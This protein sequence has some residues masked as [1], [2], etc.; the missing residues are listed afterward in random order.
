MI[1]TIASL[2][3]LYRTFVHI[4]L[5]YWAGHPHRSRFCP[6]ADGE[7]LP[8]FARDLDRNLRAMSAQLRAGTYRFSPFLERRV[9]VRGG[10]EKRFSQATLRDTLVQKA[11]AAIVE[12][13]LDPLLPDSLH[14]F[15]RRRPGGPGLHR[16]LSHAAQVSAA[17]S[18]WVLQEDVRA[19]YDHIRHDRLLETLSPLLAGQQPVLDLYAAYLVAPRQVDGVLQPRSMGLPIGSTLANALANVYLL[20]LDHA[21]GEAGFHAMRY[22]DDVLVWAAGQEEALAARQVIVE[23]TQAYG[24]SLN[25]EKSCLAPPSAPFIYLGYAFE[26]PHMRIGPRATEKLRRKVARVTARNRWPRLTPADLHTPRGRVLL[27]RLIG[28]VNAQITGN[29]LGAWPRYFARAEFDTQFRELDRWIRQ[30]VRAALLH[31]WRESDAR[32]LPTAQLQALGLNSLVHETWRWRKAWRARNRSLLAQAAQLTR[33]RASLELTKARAWDRY[34][35]CHRFRPGPDGLTLD[36]IAAD[37]RTFLL[38]LQTELLAGRYRFGAFLEYARPRQGRDEPRWIARPGLADAVVA[39]ALSAVLSTALEQHLPQHTYAYRSGKGNWAAMGQLRRWLLETETPWVVR[40]DVAGFLDQVD[41]SALEA[42]LGRLLPASGEM[43]AE[44]HDLLR[45][46]LW[47]GR[48]RAEEGLLPRAEGLPRGGPLTP[49]LGNLALLPLDEALLAEGFR[50][51]RYADDVV[52]VAHTEAEAQTA[53]ALI[54]RQALALGLPLSTA[55][56]GVFSPTTPFEFLGYRITG[57]HVAV[58]PYA[59]NRLKR[60]VRRVTQRRRW[61]H[62]TVRS[63]QT[64]AGQAELARLVRQLNRLLVYGAGFD[65]ARRFA[66]CSDDA[67]FRELDRWIADRVRAC[68]TGRWSPRNRRLVPAYLLREQ[69]LVRLV[70]LYYHARRRIAGQAARSDLA[71]RVQPSPDAGPG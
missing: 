15:R 8:A 30:R 4:Q 62:L 19:Y 61:P 35:R 70:D 34:R 48:W 65:W 45:S 14:A 53:W 67:Q 23:I 60:R 68:V 31:R 69:G 10:R 3:H 6:G 49:L 5:R 51:L 12:P 11:V 38:S 9:T 56:S 55:K 20:P 63:L 27:G 13:A 32:Y 59:L 58:R 57:H 64:P 71:V 24:L 25:P 21:L 22:C 36:D 46:Y 33:L 50:A 47:A 37:E 42:Q 52:V 54:Q 2:D 28:E 40:A 41:L 7:T 26:G 39:R 66:R 43:D 29:A 18:F 17:E 1:E 44:L 16:A